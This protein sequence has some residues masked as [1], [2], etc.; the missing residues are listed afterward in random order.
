MEQFPSDCVDL[1]FTDPPYNLQKAYTTY[2]DDLAAKEYVIWC[3]KWLYQLYRILN[4]SGSL[5]V[6]N[7]PKWCIYYAIFLDKLMY[8][9][10]W[11]IWD[12]LSIPRGKLMPAHYGLLYY[13][14]S[15]DNYTF[16]EMTTKSKESFCYRES[17]VKRRETD[18]NVAVKP[19]PDLWFD[20]HRVR[21]RKDRDPHPCQLPLSLVERIILLASKK[22][23]LVFDPF[24]GVG[25]TAIVAKLLDRDYTG[26]EI[27][28]EYVSIS[29]QKIADHETFR[30]QLR[31]MNVKQQ[32]RKIA[33]YFK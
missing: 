12:A 11:I 31:V 28:P 24:I 30:Q 22:G 1:V 29:E 13:T 4:P 9:Q 14:K 5:F 15:R 7:L 19:L 8:R 3:N 23:E 2:N 18:P 33:G 25:T 26:I 10:Q 6:V 20:L 16:N 32:Q 21:H 17:C 27:D